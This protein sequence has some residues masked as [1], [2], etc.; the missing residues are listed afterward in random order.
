MPTYT[1]YR[2]VLPAMKIRLRFGPPKVKLPMTSG[3][4]IRPK[5]LPDGSQTVMPLYPTLRPA[6][7]DNH[8]FPL[9]SQRTPSG[10]HLMPSTT[11]SLNFCMFE[12]DLPSALTSNTHISPLPPAMVSPGPLPVLATYSFLWSCE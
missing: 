9:M 7:L 8:T 1:A 5:S 10:P 2:D 11:Q 6:L 3:S 12:T 4:R